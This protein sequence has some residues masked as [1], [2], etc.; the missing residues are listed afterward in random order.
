MLGEPVPNRFRPECSRE[1]KEWL[2]KS[3]AET[4][5]PGSNVPHIIAYVG[6]KH[7]V[8]LNRLQERFDRNEL[9]HQRHHLE[10]AKVIARLK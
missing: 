4:I 1:Y 6:A 7:Q 3:L 10:D 8:R 5:E 2:K 9:E